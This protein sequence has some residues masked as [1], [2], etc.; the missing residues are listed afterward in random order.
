MKSNGDYI[1]ISDKKHFS[2]IL[3][4]SKCKRM[5]LDNLLIKEWYP[6]SRQ[7][8]WCEYTLQKRNLFLT[9]YNWKLNKCFWWGIYILYKYTKPQ[10][11][12]I[13]LWLQLLELHELHGWIVCVTKFN[14]KLLD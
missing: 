14:K 11:N 8:S 6:G 5:C 3:G 1:L 2:V 4:G 7:R 13:L 12:K 9:L 10:C